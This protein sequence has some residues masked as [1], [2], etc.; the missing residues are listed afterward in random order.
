[1]PPL[2]HTPS[3]RAQRQLLFTVKNI[4]GKHVAQTADSSEAVRTFTH[5]DTDQAT[6]RIYLARVD[7]AVL[8]LHSIVSEC[9]IS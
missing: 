2:R 9:T 8:T 1:M 4:N 7:T 6:H 3:W 5:S